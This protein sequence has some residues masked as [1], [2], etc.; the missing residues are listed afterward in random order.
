MV[1]RSGWG[2]FRIFRWHISGAFFSSG[3][4]SPRNSK[5]AMA[6]QTKPNKLDQAVQSLERDLMAEVNALSLDELKE[7]AIK[8][9]RLKY[10]DRARSS[11][12]NQSNREKRRQYYHA[13]TKGK[14]QAKRQ[15][16]KQAGRPGE[17][18]EPEL[19]IQP[20]ENR[21]SREEHMSQAGEEAPMDI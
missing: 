1:I 2:I 15:A 6:E 20:E 4:K 13:V 8:S 14:R 10:Y 3:D 11:T 12:Y 21:T 18:G 19:N 9:L 16:K 5:I 7:Y 17:P